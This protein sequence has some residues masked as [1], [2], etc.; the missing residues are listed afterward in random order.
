MPRLFEQALEHHRAGDLQQAEAAYRTLL[1][2]DPQHADALQLLGVIAYQAGNYDAAIDLITQA[3][4]KNAA[5][6]A[7]HSNLGMALQARGDLDESMRCFRRAL[8]LLPDYPEAHYNLGNALLAKGQADQAITCYQRALALVPNYA[9]AYNNMGSALQSLERLTEAVACYNQ[10]LVIYPDFVEAHNNMGNALRE[11]GKLDAA[12]IH[13]Q[14]ALAVNPD[15]AGAHNHLGNVYQDLGRLDD[16]EACYQRAL[17]LQPDYAD[18]YNNLGE[19]RKL[20][21]QIDAALACYQQALALQPNHAAAN[22]NH[23]LT[24]LLIGDY[25]EGWKKYEWR[26]QGATGYWKARRQFAQPQWSGEDIAGRT[27]LLHA[28]QGLGDALQFIRYA[29]L[30]AERAGRVIVECPRPLERL[31]AGVQGIH[32][33]VVQG[34]ELPPF[35]VHCPLLSLP[36]AFGTSLETIPARIPYLVPEESLV[37]DWKT[38]LGKKDGLRVGLVWAGN[39]RKHDQFA[40]LIDQRR[41]LSLAH[42]APLAAVAGIQYYSLQK[43]EAAAQVSQ[44]PS[45]MELIDFTDAL[46]DFSDTAALMANLDLLITVDTSVAHL[47]GGMGKPVWLLSR[48]DGCWR[49][50]LNRADSPWYPGM[51]LFRQQ[52]P[53]DWTGV[54]EQVRAELVRVLAMDIREE[55]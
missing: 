48:F 26:W 2:A 46:H 55:A 14:R 43:G 13:Y 9:Q 36:L 32:Q 50:L 5:A 51:R 19:T 1:A 15:F 11:Q 52:T 33:L 17:A 7:Y 34:D 54:I 42:F 31:F 47:A 20:Q 16:A 38:R 49:W 27:I 8:E 39:P 24:L 53:G 40:S 22:W 30:V 44:P 25:V 29:P 28:E 21:G 23:A 18:A 6:P 35:D 3:L 4:G 10:A 37:Q 41:S 12:I 45:G